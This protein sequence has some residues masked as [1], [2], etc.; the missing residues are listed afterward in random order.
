MGGHC[1]FRPIHV[2]KP[3]FVTS[4]KTQTKQEAVAAVMAAWQTEAAWRADLRR[5]T[6]TQHGCWAI[7]LIRVIYGR[8]WGHQ[9]RDA[10]IDWPSDTERLGE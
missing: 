5:I 6:S 1:A 7:S 3:K 2:A 4:G 9:H 10:W 8:G